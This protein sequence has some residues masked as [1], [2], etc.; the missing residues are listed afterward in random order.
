M[1]RNDLVLALVRAGV[2]GDRDASRRVAEAIAVDERA[3]Q[4]SALADRLETELKA[5]PKVTAQA[6]DNLPGLQ[7]RTPFRTLD[8]VLLPD[9]T[10]TLIDEFV[11]EQVR[12]DLL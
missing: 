12:S 10:R 9:L 5:T 4:R 11:E 1:A 3:K 7:I 8:S 6:G 2:A